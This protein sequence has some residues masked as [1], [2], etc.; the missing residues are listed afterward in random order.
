MALRNRKLLNL[1]ML[2]GGFG[3]GQGSIFL[4]QTVL[5]AEGRLDLLAAFGL[6]FSFAI[7][8]L[9]LVDW[10]SL[11][12]LARETA[13]ATADEAD[14]DRI[15][16]SWWAMTPVRLLVAAA[17][18]AAG[19]VYAI[20]N[21][22]G[23]GGAFVLGA[24]PA[25]LIWSL[26]ANGILDGLKRAGVSGMTGSLPY[27][28]TAAALFVARDWQLETAGLTVGLALSA[29][30]LLSILLQQ[31]AIA[32]AGHGLRLVRPSGNLIWTMAQQGFA[33]CLSLLPGQL[34]FRFQ[35]GLSA[36]VL[37]TE[38]TAIFIYAKQLVAAMTQLVG[39]L[40]R[41]EFPDLVAA[42]KEKLTSNWREVLYRQRMG[43][44]AALLF[45][46]TLCL[47]G[48]FSTALLT[49]NTASAG[50]WIASF[51][52]TVLSGAIALGMQQGLFALGHFRQ[53]ASLRI[54]ATGLGALASAALVSQLGLMAFIVADLIQDVVFLLIIATLIRRPGTTSTAK[55]NL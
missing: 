17:V 38:L 11:T 53:A 39:F 28:G 47:S 36:S 22:T 51:S 45:T 54:G 12:V 48:F 40:R 37:G 50:V 46:V 44:I 52:P 18:I 41:I 10:G 35:L 23:F 43:T 3:L 34:Y 49:G 2:I 1:A 15:W 26:N 7:L 6:H 27:L 19:L 30:Y 24:L 31:V 42:L 21:D 29:A 8:G 16:R 9:L 4:V 55:V 33:A 14:H 25:A 13:T 20:S 5:V 32:R